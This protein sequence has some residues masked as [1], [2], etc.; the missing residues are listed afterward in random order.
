MVLSSPYVMATSSTY[1]PAQSWSFSVTGTQ[2]GTAAA[3]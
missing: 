1:C 3:A 2:A